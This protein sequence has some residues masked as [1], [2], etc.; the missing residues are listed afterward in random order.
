MD[1]FKIIYNQIKEFLNNSNGYIPNISVPLVVVI[2]ENK[3][4]KTISLFW[5][6]LDSKIELQTNN[7]KLLISKDG[8]SCDNVL[9]SI[10][11]SDIFSGLK[12]FALNL[13][14]ENELDVKVTKYD[15]ENYSSHLGIANNEA[16]NNL[17]FKIFSGRNS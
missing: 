9:S 13:S 16:K 10:S 15:D 12:D 17:L 11:G 2:K 8:K 3:V 4:I 14:T 7:M 1:N 6:E 5:T